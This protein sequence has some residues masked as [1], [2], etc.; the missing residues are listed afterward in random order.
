MPYAEPGQTSFQ[1]IAAGDNSL[2]VGRSFRPDRQMLRE[3]TGIRRRTGEEDG[4]E[5]PQRGNDW[6]SRRWKTRPTLAKKRPRPAAVPMRPA[7][8][9]TGQCCR[10][11][12]R[13]RPCG[14]I[15]RSSAAPFAHFARLGLPRGSCRKTVPE[16]RFPQGS[17]A[18][19]FVDWLVEF[20]RDPMAFVLRDW[21]VVCLGS[22]RCFSKERQNA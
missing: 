5:Q 16:A 20:T 4:G 9:P 13:H 2:V 7:Q 17:C 18:V 10:R 15:N 1:S 12:A 14:T 22:R 21:R 6:F 3:T 19:P 11:L 8:R